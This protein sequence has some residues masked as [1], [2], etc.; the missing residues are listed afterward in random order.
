[1]TPDPRPL[2]AIEREFG[3]LNRFSFRSGAPP[4]KNAGVV[5]FRRDAP[6]GL[7][8]PIL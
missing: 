7:R 4:R 6:L 8:G 1:M 3:S 5:Q 2:V